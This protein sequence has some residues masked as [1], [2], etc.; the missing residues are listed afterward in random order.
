[1]KIL[2]TGSSGFIGSHLVEHL[3]S[4]NYKVIAFDRYNS[5]NDLGW[6][7]SSKFKNKINFVL[8]D[9]R[10]YDSVF[11]SMQGCDAVIH[12]A[13]LIGTI[14]IFFT[15]SLRKDK[16]RRNPQYIRG[17]KKFKNETS[18]CNFYK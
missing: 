12:L 18:Y 8:G 13:A 16:Y 4:Q 2:V 1:M 11:K 15:Y 7:E 14:F 10:D 6:L 3:V 5:N 9:I 17:S